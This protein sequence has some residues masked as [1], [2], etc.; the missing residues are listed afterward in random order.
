MYSFKL[1]LIAYGKKFDPF[2]RREK[3]DASR[4]STQ[5][6]DTEYLELL[7]VPTGD[8]RHESGNIVFIAQ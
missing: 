1:T 7:E 5:K 2:T 8:S 4:P 3:N 6:R